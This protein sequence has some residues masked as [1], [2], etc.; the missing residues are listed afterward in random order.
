MSAARTQALTL[1]QAI[2][3][4]GGGENTQQACQVGSSGELI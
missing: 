4:G 3:G 2:L 1:T